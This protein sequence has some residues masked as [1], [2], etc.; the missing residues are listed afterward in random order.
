[1]GI[2]KKIY[3]IQK[4]VFS[5]QCFRIQGR[6]YPERYRYR[7]EIQTYRNL[8]S[9]IG[10]LL[11]TICEV[12]FCVKW[13]SGQLVVKYSSVWSTTRSSRQTSS[14]C[15]GL[16]PAAEGFFC[17]KKKSLLC[18]FWPI[19]GHFWCS[20]VTIIMFSHTLYNFEKIPKI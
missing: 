18:L 16:R 1:M 20:V 19:L 2:Q 10:L 14:S 6:W 5:P 12:L 7:T 4:H 8:V 3:N 11:G 17:P 15:E 9:S 13:R